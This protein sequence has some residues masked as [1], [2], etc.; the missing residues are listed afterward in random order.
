MA[1]PSGAV[2]FAR[3]AIEEFGKINEGMATVRVSQAELARCY[4]VSASTLGWYVGELG[5]AVVR[6]RPLT[7]DLALLIPA[8][9][10]RETAA[11]L[12]GLSES[13]GRLAAGIRGWTA[14]SR[15]PAADSTSFL[16]EAVEAV[17]DLLSSPAGF[18]GW[19]A[20][21]RDE[22]DGVLAPLV[23][24]AARLGLTG[25]VHPDGVRAALAGYPIE[26]V[27][28]AVARLVTDIERGARI[29]RPFGVLVARAAAGDNDLFRPIAHAALG[30]NVVPFV[31][32]APLVDLEAGEDGAKGG[33]L[34]PIPADL[35]PDLDREAAR[36]VVERFPAMAE[37]MLANAP[38]RRALVASLWK[39]RCAGQPTSAGRE[40]VS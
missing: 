27:V 15:G 19:S 37:R 9:P 22:L 34:P 23:Q 16:K 8:G 2:S 3:W 7:F 39:E 32:R 30:P 36:R 4:G 20:D 40:R 11:E 33:Q 14:S 21:S 28:G 18:D 35:E 24:V 6:R 12:A 10:S 38:L 13:F 26:D 17:D 25:M 1:R 29:R 31:P 5:D